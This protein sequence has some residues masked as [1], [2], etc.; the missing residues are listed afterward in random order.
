MVWAAFTLA[1]FSFLCCCELTYPGTSRFCSKVNLSTNWVSS[2]PNLTCPQQMPLFLK[3]SKTDSFC[4]GHTLITACSTLLVCPVTTIH[5]YYFSDCLH[6]QA[7]FYFQSG[8]LLT[9]LAVV[10][11]HQDAVRHASLP[12]KTL[13]GHSFSNGA[14]SNQSGR[15]MTAALIF[16]QMVVRL[17]STLYMYTS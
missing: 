16:K 6:V 9:K 7:P 15:L 2:Y 11:L 4:Q 17:L 12:F 3:A 5:D 1:F 8:H 14:A 10:N 13:K